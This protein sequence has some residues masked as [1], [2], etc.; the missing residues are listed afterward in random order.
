[1]KILQS[2]IKQLTNKLDGLRL[3]PSN[4]K[5]IQAISRLE[6][7]IEILEK[8]ERVYVGRVLTDE[9]REL[10]KKIIKLL[11]V[12]NLRALDVAKKCNCSHQTVYRVKRAHI[13][14][15]EANKN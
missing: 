6:K 2:Q 11:F 9:E 7:A 3:K 13:A 1:M 14:E 8:P 15:Q 10:H 12:N 4:G 5:Y